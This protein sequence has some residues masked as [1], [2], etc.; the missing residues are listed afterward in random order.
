MENPKIETGNIEIQ[1]K[2]L[3]IISEAKT[4]P[5]SLKLMAMRF[6]RRKD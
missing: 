5:F 1:A 3:K 4:L 6:Q 2:D